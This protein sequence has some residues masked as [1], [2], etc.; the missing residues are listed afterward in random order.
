MKYNIL[1]IGLLLIVTNN[2]SFGEKMR[3]KNRRNY[4][5]KV[6]EKRIVDNMDKMQLVKY[7]KY[8][9]NSN[10]ILVEPDTKNNTNTNTNTNTNL[11]ENSSDYWNYISL[12][13]LFNLAIVGLYSIL[14]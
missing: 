9:Y 8:N 5:K 6:E 14:W 10:N 7:Y 4:Y 12:I 11:V 3:A 13:D 2:T 1:F